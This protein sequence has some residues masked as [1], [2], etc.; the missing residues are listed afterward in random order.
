M[1]TIHAKYNGKLRSTATHL[2]SN[3]SLITD[4]PLDNNGKGE[5]FSPTDLVATAL[6]TCI[7]TIMGIYARDN[8]ISLEET[9]IDINKTMKDN[10]R[11]IGKIEIIFTMPKLSLSDKQ[12]KEIEDI[13]TCCPV[14]LSL[15]PELEKDIKFI[16]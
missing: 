7:M 12:K 5:S 6:G 14:C 13:A 9:K 3:C 1:P 2:Q 16:W 8:N 15:H 11:R 4:A 10:P